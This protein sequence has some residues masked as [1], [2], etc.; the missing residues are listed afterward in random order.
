MSADAICVPMVRRFTFIVDIALAHIVL[1][2]G[3]YGS[4]VVLP[5][6]TCASMNFPAGLATLSGPSA[7]SEVVIVTL[8]SLAT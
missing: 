8:S 7:V 6:I 3:H 2:A 4:K 5:R 1:T